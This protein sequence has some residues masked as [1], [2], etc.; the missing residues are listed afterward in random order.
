MTLALEVGFRQ[1][2]TPN[3]IN[4]PLTIVLEDMVAAKNYLEEAEV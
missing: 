2:P 4:S 1:K 3:Q